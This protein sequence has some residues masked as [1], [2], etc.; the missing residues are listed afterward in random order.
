MRAGQRLADRGELGVQPVLEGAVALPV[1]KYSKRT[2]S[3]TQAVKMPGRELIRWASLT[4]GC[5]FSIV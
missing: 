3:L 5:E 1:L 4:R 2:H